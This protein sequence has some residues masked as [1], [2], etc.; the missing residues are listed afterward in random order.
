MKTLK[1]NKEFSE[2]IPHLQPEE[3]ILL[4][5]SIQK[6]GCRDPIFIWN[7]TI[8]DG[9]NRYQ[10]CK[11][12]K[13]EYKTKEIKF[14]DNNEAKIWIINNQL[15]RR[16]LSAYA[17]VELN[18]ILE[19][20]LSPGQGYRSDLEPLSNLTKVNTS[21]EIAKQSKVAEGTVHKVKFI[22]DNADEETK[23]KLREGNKELSI[24]KVYST[25][26]KFFKPLK[27]LR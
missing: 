15:A 20:I 11:K 3:Y 23:E 12:H 27:L 26:F 22:R 24:N 16:N 5:E 7:D 14:K 17:K 19:D 2:L 25:L 6:E 13:I 8:I 10:I 18:L 4:E 1:I 9:Y 21:K